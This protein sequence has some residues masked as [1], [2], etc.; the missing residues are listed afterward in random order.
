MAPRSIW[1]GVISFGM[2][3]IPVKLFNA[4]SGND[5]AFVTLHKA[6]RQRLRQKRWC[7]QHE[8]EVPSEETAR[9]YEYSKDQY[10]IVE[11]TE[12]EAFRVPSTHTIEITQFTDLGKVDPVYFEKS[13]VLEPEP[14]GIKPFY[15]L[16]KAMEGAGL[17]ALA[18]ISIRQK[19]NLCALRVYGNTIMLHTMYYADELR[20]L[21]ELNLPED[22]VQIGTQEKGMAKLLVEHLTADFKPEGYKD[23]YRETVLS[24][25]ESKLNATAPVAIPAAP[26]QGKVADLMEALKASIEAAKKSRPGR[27]AEP[28]PEAREAKAEPADKKSRAKK[29]VAARR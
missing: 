12:L 29:A 4:T 20:G 23:R 10:V 26:A 7:P 8:V 17:A 9:G 2:V 5:L 18:T 14:V 27:A 25:I 16:K 15:L 1:K 3:T 11:D 24:L 22:T 6:C 13:Y 19:E 21:G 28:A